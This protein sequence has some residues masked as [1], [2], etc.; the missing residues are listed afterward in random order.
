MCIGTLLAYQTATIANTYLHRVALI[1]H[2]F[3]R[4]I[5]LPMPHNHP[6][7]KSQCFWS[8]P[9]NFADQ[10]DILR[11]DVDISPYHPEYPPLITLYKITLYDNPIR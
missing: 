2:V 1:Q 5:P 7:R 10:V 11:W 8:Q 4:V 6:K 9:I 3:T